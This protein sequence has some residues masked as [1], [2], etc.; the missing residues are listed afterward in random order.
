MNECNLCNTYGVH[1]CI[2]CFKN[3]L[4][5]IETSAQGQSIILGF[6]NKPFSKEFGIKWE[7]LRHRHRWVSTFY[8]EN[9]WECFECFFNDFIVEN[10]IKCVSNLS[11]GGISKMK[12]EI[13]NWQCLNGEEHEWKAKFDEVKKKGC[14]ECDKKITYPLSIAEVISSRYHGSVLKK[15]EEN[16]EWKCKEGHQWACD[17]PTAEKYWCEECKGA[18]VSDLFDFFM[19]KA[20]KSRKLKCLTPKKDIYKRKQI[21][22]WQCDKEHV[23]ENS[24]EVIIM[25]KWCPECLEINIILKKIKEFVKTKKGKCLTPESKVSKRKNQVLKWQCVND[26]TWDNTFDVAKNKWCLDCEKPII[27]KIEE[28]IES[29]QGKCLTLKKDITGRVNQVLRWQC[30]ESHEW[31]N[32]LAVAKKRWCKE[33]RI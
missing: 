20:L 7:C 13:M 12:T 29:K 23:W 33:C 22:K 27:K 25:K 9:C 16:F 19:I 21:L 6:I 32:T 28:F 26:H 10:N 31:D 30:K 18:P 2:N 5:V 11:L 15:S 3:F 17:F 14:P 4:E 24:L 8:D 1:Y